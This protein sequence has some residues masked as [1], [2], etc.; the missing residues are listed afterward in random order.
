MVVWHC[1]VRSSHKV[2][3]R[4]QGPEQLTV[5]ILWQAQ[6][7]SLLRDQT[8]TR[9][10]CSSYV[11]TAGGPR[12]EFLGSSGKYVGGNRHEA[13]AWAGRRILSLSAAG[14]HINPLKSLTTL[15]LLKFC[16]T[17]LQTTIQLYLD[18]WFSDYGWGFLS[19]VGSREYV[20]LWRQ[21]SEASWGK[22]GGQSQPEDGA[23]APHLRQSGKTFRLEKPAAFLSPVD[24]LIGFQKTVTLQSLGCYLHTCLPTYLLI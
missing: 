1:D 9:P 5:F 21:R 18:L 13:G 19:L 24:P 12:S 10:A 22:G 2:V 11:T 17:W 3:L 7:V 6:C 16:F 14:T 15:L 8:A 20:R 4:S 23:S